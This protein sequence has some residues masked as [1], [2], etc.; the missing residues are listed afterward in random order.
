MAL[1]DFTFNH[2]GAAAL[3]FF[4]TTDDKVLGSD[5]IWALIAGATT[6]YF[7][8]TAPGAVNLGTGRQLNRLAFDLQR[9]HRGP[10]PKK[11]FVGKYDGA[12]PANT[13][14]PTSSEEIYV[15]FGVKNVQ[16][17][18]LP[19]TMSCRT[20]DGFAVQLNA[21]VT[22]DGRPVNLL[23]CGRAD[24]P[25]TA[26]AGTDVISCTGHGLSNGDAIIFH[27]LTGT[28]PTGITAGTV[29]YVINA[30]TDDF[31]ISATSGGSALNITGAG[32]PP[33][34]F[35]VPTCTI[36][37]REHGSGVAA[38]TKTMTAANIR[39]N[40][41]GNTCFEVENPPGSTFTVNTGTDVVTSTAHGLSDTN[42]IVVA[43]GPGGTLPAPLSQSTTYFVRDA[44]TDTFK[45]ALTSGG[46]A[47]DITTA[48][49]GTFWWVPAAA[50][51]T[52]DRQ[53]EIG[54]SMVLAGET[55]TDT[56]PAQTL[57]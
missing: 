36:T 29:Y 52:A 19:A 43:T 22:A 39:T 46:S 2:T 40:A 28:L 8:M 12:T 30:N 50:L 21:R 7:G 16:S 53:F 34:Y 33:N 20:L 24:K 14:N 13:V 11:I 56:W 41:D 57:G 51:L 4:R 32:A 35:D 18:R 15:T 54:V 31:Q 45:L 9:L 3:R 47:I 37:V 6:P 38:F 10:L 23:T 48:G 5:E 42:Q 27:T 17:V 1:E 55:I 26:D 49:T 25:F 44:T